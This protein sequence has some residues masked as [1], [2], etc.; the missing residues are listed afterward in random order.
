[1]LSII[2]QRIKLS[3]IFEGV[4]V[5]FT[6]RL[7]GMI[8]YYGLHYDCY[9]YNPQRKQWLVFDDR[10]VKEV[11]CA[12]TLLLQN[13]KQRQTACVLILQSLQVGATWEQLKD[14]CRRGKFHPSVLFY[15]RVESETPLPTNYSNSQYAAL[16][17]NN[18]PRR[19][20]PVQY[21]VTLPF[22]GSQ[23]DNEKPN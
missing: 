16:V 20:L 15:E 23:H 1:M 9:F 18:P 12:Y 4:P 13:A 17:A 21:Q 22:T 8:C 7:K 2:S 11:G 6:Y 10:V 3:N 14:R 19:H 5:Q